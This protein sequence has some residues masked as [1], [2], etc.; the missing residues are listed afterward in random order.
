[1]MT[2]S[3]RRQTVGRRASDLQRE[4]ELA[5]LRAEIEML[6]N[7][8]NHLLRTTGAAAMFVAKLDT[9]VLPEN[10]YE[11][12][13]ILASAI[14]HLPEETLHDAVE[15]IHGIGDVQRNGNLGILP[16]KRSQQGRKDILARNATAPQHQFP[17]HTPLEF[18]QGLH[19]CRLRGEETAGIAI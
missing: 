17:V 18:V 9:Q 4:R 16:Q 12:A 19:R 13:E 14:N 8:R 6:I 10:T 3:E 5:M 2:D 11:A 1:M 15:R 7:E